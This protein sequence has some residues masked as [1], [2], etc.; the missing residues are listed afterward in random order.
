MLLAL[1][2]QQISYAMEATA[3]EITIDSQT[4]VY[5]LIGNAV[6]KYKGKVFKADL[7]VVYKDEKEKL[8]EKITARGNVSFNEDGTIITAD[9]CES[10][11]KFVTFY[12]NVTLKNNE[13]GV[14]YADKARYDIETKKMD[15]TAKNKVK[16]ILSKDKED[17][18]NRKTKK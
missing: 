5:T 10:D 3:D 18:F 12:Q 6:A 7:I 13:I 11:K 14:V 2:C 8:P 16:V 9:S 15:V 17:E 1:L 4:N